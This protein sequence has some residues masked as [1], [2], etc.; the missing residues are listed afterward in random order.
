MHRVL[1]Y[2][3]K[4]PLLFLMSQVF[5]FIVWSWVS[6]VRGLVNGSNISENILYGFSS[7]VGSSKCLQNIDSYI[8]NHLASVP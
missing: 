7:E 3:R 8:P 1:R 5:C 6:A 2:L 4:Y